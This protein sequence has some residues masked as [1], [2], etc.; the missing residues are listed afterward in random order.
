MSGSL[1]MYLSNHEQSARPSAFAEATADRR[2]AK[3]EGWS[4]SSGRAVRQ[5]NCSPGLLRIH[6]RQRTA[7]YGAAVHFHAF[8]HG[9]GRF[10]VDLCDDRRFTRGERVPDL[11][12]EIAGDA[13]LCLVIRRSSDEAAGRADGDSHGTAKEAEET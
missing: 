13:Q 7:E 2:S 5:F 8:I 3:R 11:G 6:T 10:F 1:R 9:P 12:H 4:T